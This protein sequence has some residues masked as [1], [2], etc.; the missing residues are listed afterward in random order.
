[1]AELMQYLSHVARTPSVAYFMVKAS[2]DR[3]TESETESAER[4]KQF[5]SV[6]PPEYV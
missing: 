4:C 2:G 6:A 1:M 3:E 5:P